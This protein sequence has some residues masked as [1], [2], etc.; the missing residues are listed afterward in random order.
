MKRLSHSVLHRRIFA[1]HMDNKM[2]TLAFSGWE[3]T[4]LSTGPFQGAKKE[5]WLLSINLSRNW[6]HQVRTTK[7]GLLN[8]GK[9]L[10][11]YVWW[12]IDVVQS[13]SVHISMTSPGPAGSSS[14]P[15]LAKPWDHRDS[16]L[17]HRGKL[18]GRDPCR[19]KSHQSAKGQRDG[20]FPTA[21][22]CWDWLFWI[23]FNKFQGLIAV[24]Q[25]LLIQ[26]H[27]R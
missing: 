6:W 25:T 12:S 23:Q 20:C 13:S 10:Q 8:S 9:S 22:T 1:K 17:K 5:S 19:A 16:H 14:C 26:F 21:P 2:N 7:D 15:A 24:W 18:M 11:I 4:Q 27:L 3:Q